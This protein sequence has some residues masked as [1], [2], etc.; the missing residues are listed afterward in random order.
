M[1]LLECDDKDAFGS[2]RM[3]LRPGSRCVL[4]RVKQGE[5]MVL[6]SLRPSWLLT[7]PA[8]TVTVPSSRTISR[9]HLIINVADV[10]EEDGVCLPPTNFSARTFC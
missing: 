3:W 6:L 2:K 8:V 1:W 10:N 4:G 9:T 5:G 7:T